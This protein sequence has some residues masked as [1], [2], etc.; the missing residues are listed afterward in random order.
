VI[1]GTVQYGPFGG[2]IPANA[3][4]GDL[5]GNGTVNFPDFLVLAEN[6]GNEVSQYS[7]GDVDCNGTVQFPDFLTLAENFG[8]SLGG[9]AA[10]V[11]EP[12]SIGLFLLGLVSL[13]I[14]RRRRR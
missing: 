6:F 11:P 8:K 13:L 10:A 7:A 4:L 5:D 2:C 12:N 1:A 3:L 14:S 9:Q